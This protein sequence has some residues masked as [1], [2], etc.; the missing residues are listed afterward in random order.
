METGKTTTPAQHRAVR[1]AHRRVVPSI[2][3]IIGIL[4][5]G[6]AIYAYYWNLFSLPEQIV[7]IVALIIALVAVSAVSFSWR[8]RGPAAR[9]PDETAGRTTST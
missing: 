4:A 3:L 2:I 9:P 8:T 5:I 1:R 6:V 7:L